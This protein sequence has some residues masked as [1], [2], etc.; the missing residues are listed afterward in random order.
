MVATVFSANFI[1]LGVILGLG[2][3]LPCLGRGLKKCEP[4]T[5]P[6]CQGLSYNTTIFPNMFNHRTQEEATL[7][8]NQFVPLVVKSACSDDLQF[9][10]CSV[11]APMCSELNTPIPPCRSL[12]NSVKHGCEAWMRRSG[13]TWPESLICDRFPE[14]GKEICVAN[15]SEATRQLPTAKRVKRASG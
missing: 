11:Y 13:F 7:E 8:L 3:V 14:H 15:T 12:C 4:M 5:I 2:L 1:R 9:F 10:L 6:L